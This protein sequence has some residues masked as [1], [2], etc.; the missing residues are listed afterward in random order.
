VQYFN[1]HSPDAV[2]SCASAAKNEKQEIREEGM[3]PFNR[4][5]INGEKVKPVLV[6]K[7]AQAPPFSHWSITCWKVSRGDALGK[8]NQVTT[9][10]MHSDVLMH[11]LMMSVRD[12]G[13]LANQDENELNMAQKA[14]GYPSV[15]MQAGG[16]AHTRSEEGEVMWVILLKTPSVNVSYVPHARFDSDMWVS[17]VMIDMIDKAKIMRPYVC[18]HK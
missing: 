9:A 16:E 15:A 1:W 5:S 10:Y 4:R 14:F 12:N 6:R 11:R 17:Q 13:D 8:H 18:P 7:G 3:K 2:S